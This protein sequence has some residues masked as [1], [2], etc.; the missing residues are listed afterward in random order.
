MKKVLF[1]FATILVLAVPVQSFSAETS[2]GNG[3]KEWTIPDHVLSITKEN[4]YPNPS[5]DIPTLQPSE[6]AQELL[7]SVDVKIENPALIRI[8]NESTIHTHTLSV[9]TSAKIY[10]GKWA[11]NYQSEETN[12]NWEYKEVNVNELNNHGGKGQAKITYNQ[13]KEVKVNGGLTANIPSQND[14]KQ[15]ML[16]TAANKT[17]LPL[18]FET[19]VGVGTKKGQE[20]NV[21]PKKV[22]QLTSYVPA[23]NEKGKVMYGEVYIVIDGNDKKLEIKNVTQQ[24]IGAWIPVQD[25]LSFQFHAR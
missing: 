14:V 18:S 15:M 22:G 23:I 25:H 4:T 16:M 1:L 5:Q 12:A 19:V 7:D 9:G 21:A 20:Y 6:L 8:F 17:K 11:L 2:K 3:E 13:K 10:L 24:G